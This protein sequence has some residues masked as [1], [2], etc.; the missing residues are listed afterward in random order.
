MQPT[1]ADRRQ[2]GRVSNESTKEGFE[3]GS[4]R[5]V[6]VAASVWIARSRNA[7][8]PDTLGA[9]QVVRE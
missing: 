4:P 9:L 1:I 5:T 8:P 3:I 2:A 7:V 6:D